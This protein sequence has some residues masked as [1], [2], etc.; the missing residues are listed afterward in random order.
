MNRIGFGVFLTIGALLAL[1]AFPSL[2]ADARPAAKKIILIAGTK[3][4]GPGEHEYEK[5][6]RLL[7]QCLDSSP[8]LHGY[9]TEVYTDGWPRDA[10]AFD[11]AATVMF[12]CDGSDHDVQAHPLLRSNH[13]ETIQKLMDR[14]VGFVA[15][16]YTVFVPAKRGG[17]QFLDWIG[18][19]FD[20]ESG[21]G[22]NH[23]Y[24]KI[25]N[26]TAKVT[27]ISP[28]HPIN[29][30]LKPFELKE[31]FYYNMRFRPDDKRLT[32]IQSAAIPDEKPQIVAWAVQRK[33]GGRG[34]AY[35]GGHYHSNWNNENVRRMV[36]NALVW[37]AKGEVPAGG[38][39]STLP[40]QTSK[41]LN[42]RPVDER[43]KA[44]LIDHSP[45]ESFCSIK[46]DSLGRLFVGCRE[47][48]FV[49]EPDGKGGYQPRRE[50]YRFPPDAWLAG[51]EIRGD[52]LYVLTN[53]ALYLLP[54]GRTKREGLKPKRL[55]WGM[56]LNIHNSCHCLAWG[57]EGD[58]Y[59]DHGDPLLDYGDFSRPDHFGHWTIHCQPEG[60]TIPYSGSGGVFRIRPDGSDFRQ[61]A[62]GLRGCV[63]LCFDHSWNLFTNDNDHESK[64]DLYTPARLMYVSQSI[65][66]AW[67]RG[68]IA[69]KN[70]D[71]FDLVETMIPAPGRGVPVGMTYY[72]E[73]L[74]P[75][76]YRN[77]LYQAR[78]DRFTIQRNAL[79]PHGA[80]FRAT[81][82]PFLVGRDLARPIGVA[83]GRGGRM[84]AAISYMAHNE[85]SPHYPSDLVMI[86]RADDPND[87]PFGPYDSVTAVPKLLWAELSKP[88]W[89]RRA[90]RT[91]KSCGAAA[92]C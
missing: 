23:W 42:Y 45:D 50:L 88:S 70:P 87:H 56:P 26:C 78:W 81:D 67:P 43:L 28:D 49:Y 71:R 60:T 10:K 63:G 65:D 73:P 83:V 7:K 84:F 36:L 32:P 22:P 3:S 40:K 5:G 30:G 44:V 27:P 69:S 57:P 80:E 82:V 77:C 68:W 20:Y 8:N 66:F 39:Q 13:L 74:F 19:Y 1:T 33:D 38:V 85:A 51:I 76:E 17:D 16:H 25:K 4:H 2:A 64:P 61:E 31:E 59:F 35:T 14:G 34:F 91:R 58:L 86:T 53:A 6:V 54:G 9:T 24:S 79:I 15:V 72:D 55:V 41:E 89:G 18:G 21:K 47:A 90:L 11:G 52:D 92:R 29:R 75:N 37:T 12:Y 48:L 62:G 46:V